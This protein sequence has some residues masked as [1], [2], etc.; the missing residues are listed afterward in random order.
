[1]AHRFQNT[2][3]RNERPYFQKFPVLGSVPVSKSVSESEFN[4]KNCGSESETESEQT[5]H[6]TVRSSLKFCFLVFRCTPNPCEHGGVCK[7]NSNDFYCE[8]E[9][10]GYTG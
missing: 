7:Q 3:E 10:T 4:P 2:H 5:Q 6:C 8:C 1:M 9:H